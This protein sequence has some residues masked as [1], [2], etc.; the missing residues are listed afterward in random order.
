MLSNSDW[1]TKALTDNEE[2][3]QVYSAIDSLKDVDSLKEM[4]SLRLRDSTVHLLKDSEAER[5][6]L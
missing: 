1:A 2:L 5:D 4:D 3:N 6:W